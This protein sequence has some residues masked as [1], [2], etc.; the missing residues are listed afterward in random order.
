MSE[1][2]QLPL[3]L[4]LTDDPSVTNL[5]RLRQKLLADLDLAGGLELRIGKKFYTKD[6][7]LKILDAEAK[8]NREA[9]MEYAL[10]IARHDWLR[11]LLVETRLIN[12]VAVQLSEAEQQFLAD[13]AFEA[14]LFPYL[15][16]A[17][18][19]AWLRCFETVDEVEAQYW[20]QL[21][22]TDL[23]WRARR[24]SLTSIRAYLERDAD[25]TER[26]FNSPDPR[27]AGFHGRSLLAYLPKAVRVLNTLPD[28]FQDIKTAYATAWYNFIMHQAM[29][30]TNSVFLESLQYLH[31]LLPKDSPIHEKMDKQYRLAKA[32]LETAEAAQQ[33]QQRLTAP[34]ER[35]A[36]YRWVWWVIWICFMLFRHCN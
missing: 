18:R 10:F 27:A 34:T 25:L 23:F 32:K 26:Y 28:D 24:E 33:Q 31:E 22:P 5:K 30:K 8:G 2:Y 7:L 15:K 21:H 4:T 17:Y 1:L 36:D 19:R 14:F 13:P 9:D 35:T 20:R 12:P 3:L 16:E 29:Q 6:A 11:R